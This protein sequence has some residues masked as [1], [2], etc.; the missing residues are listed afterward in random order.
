MPSALVTLRRGGSRCQEGHFPRLASRA[1]QSGALWLVCEQ[2]S[3]LAFGVAPNRLT[4]I[5]YLVIASA[6]A[7][8]G[9]LH[10]GTLLITVLFSYFALRKMQHGPNKW[11]SIALFLVLV[12]LVVYGFSFFIKQAVHAMPKILNKSVPAMVQFANEHHF[13]LPF[14]DAETL[15]ATLLDIARDELHMMGNVA[16]HAG[17]ELVLLIIG[18]VIAVSFYMNS[19][20]DLDPGAHTLR[21]NSYSFLCEEIRKRFLSLYRSF[22]LVMGAQLIISLINTS[23]TSVFVVIVGMPYAWM[24]VVATFLCGLLPIVGNLISNSIIVGVGFTMSPKMALVSLIFLVLVHKLEYFLNSKIIGTRI[25]NPVW[26]T[27]I[28]VVLGERLMGIPGMI[29]APVVLHF[30]KT[31]TA[32]VEVKSEPPTG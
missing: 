6:I 20:M 11:I 24:I 19:Q 16:K 7:L 9:W 27:L 26:L 30:L 12:A 8:T 25:K 31:E 13:E 29:L 2:G 28:G 14:S 22:D 5:S 3:C 32:S 18:F 21:N 4:T 15:K 17:R 10:M 1:G 23:L